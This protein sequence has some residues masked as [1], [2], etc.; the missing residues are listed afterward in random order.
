MRKGKLLGT[1]RAGTEDSA[2]KPWVTALLCIVVLCELADLALSYEAF[3]LLLGANFTGAGLATQV[4]RAAGLTA[5]YEAL[6]VAVV[7][8]ALVIALPTA[9]GRVCRSANGT[10]GRVVAALL[11]AVAAAV[12]AGVSWAR[13]VG[14]TAS[15]QQVGGATVAEQAMAA[16]AVS[17]EQVALVFA[18]VTLVCMAATAALSFVLA[19]ENAS[20]LTELYREYR[21]VNYELAALQA[22][23][24]RY[25]DI[26]PRLAEVDACATAAKVEVDSLVARP[27]DWGEQFARL[28]GTDDARSA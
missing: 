23:I 18:G 22:Y 4:E 19:R 27:G 8:S 13:Y 6:A 17:S 20:E 25:R 14:Q 3:G 21:K 2:R 1:L 26:E 15:G 24:G 11:L 28:Y 10:G 9:A 7:T 16:N 12:A 5:A